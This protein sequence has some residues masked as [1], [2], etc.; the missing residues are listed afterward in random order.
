MFQEFPKCLYRDGSDLDDYRIVGDQAGQDAA[1]KD[2]YLQHGAEQ[3]GAA[4]KP[5]T[6]RRKADDVQA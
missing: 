6:K 4:A 2:G 1:A 3:P 5:V